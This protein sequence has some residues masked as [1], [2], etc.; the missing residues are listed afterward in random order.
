MALWGGNDRGWCFPSVTAAKPHRVIHMQEAKE[1]RVN[2][3][4]G[5]REQFL[6]GPHVLRATFISVAAD[7]GISELDRNVLANHRYA[8]RSVN[9][10]YIKQSWD[11]LVKCQETIEA[12][13]WRRIKAKAKLRAV[14]GGRR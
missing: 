3:A 13:I 4:T 11:H 14:Q 12:E 2:E 7:A 6:P 8:S 10:T 9:E 5:E 1:R